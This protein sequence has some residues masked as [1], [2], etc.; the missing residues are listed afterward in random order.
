MISRSSIHGSQQNRQANH[1]RSPRIGAHSHCNVVTTWCTYWHGTEYGVRSSL[2][3]TPIFEKA[4]F[5]FLT[6]ASCSD[7][8]MINTAT[9]RRSVTLGLQVTIDRLH[10][11]S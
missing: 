5:L 4:V 8:L 9:I 6:A 2:Q 1:P 10:W 3:S 11:A 7:A